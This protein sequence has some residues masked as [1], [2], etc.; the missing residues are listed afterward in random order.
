MKEFANSYARNS[1]GWILFPSG[2]SHSY[3]AAMFPPE[4]STHP[5]KA[6]IH[7]VQAIIEFVS[8]PDDTLLD[9]MA[10]VGTI[11]VG[12]LIGRKVICVEISE[13]FYKMQLEA[14]KML[15][16][17]A[18]GVA[19]S[20]MCINMPCQVYLPIPNLA[21][22]IIFSPQYSGILLRKGKPSQWNIDTKYNLAEYNKNPLNLGVMSD[23]VWAEEMGR[24]YKKCYE[25]LTTPGSMTLIIKDRIEHGIR[26]DL[27]GKTIDASIEAGFS[28]SPTE[29]FRWAAPGMPFTSARKARGETVVEDESIIVL[30]KE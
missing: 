20:I 28:Y 24:V 15:E 23:F 17:M 13:I 8:K 22:H 27:T 2:K 12:A 26:I 19:D 4:A 21:N 14:V 5:A 30:R 6:N 10:G 1:K 11:M 18:P 7:L 9:I 25:S 3:R 29:H 16:N